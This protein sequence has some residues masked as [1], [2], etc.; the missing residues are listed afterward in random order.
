M[1]KGLGMEA[2]Q[3]SSQGK[4]KMID[5][6]NDGMDGEDRGDDS[7]CNGDAIGKVDSTLSLWK[8]RSGDS[9]IITLCT[10]RII[11]RAYVRK[12]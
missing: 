9:V 12:L 2:S 1:W 8:A 4:F 7:T 11:I 10:I 6:S 5:C 3:L